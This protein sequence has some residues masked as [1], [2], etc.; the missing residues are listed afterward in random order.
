M[1]WGTQV[2]KLCRAAAAEGS[3]GGG[4]PP[5]DEVWCLQGPGFGLCSLVGPQRVPLSRSGT[6]S[7][8]GIPRSPE[9]EAVGDSWVGCPVQEACSDAGACWGLVGQG[10]TEGAASSDGW[11]HRDLRVEVR[12]EN[13]AKAKARLGNK[14][15]GELSLRERAEEDQ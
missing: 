8:G 11:S 10:G 7:L 4:I 6:E 14:Q 2:H 5:G 1:P 12:E 15:Q 13:G 9:A 3:L